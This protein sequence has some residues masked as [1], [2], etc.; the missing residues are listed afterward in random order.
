MI[1]TLKKI[2]QAKIVLVGA[3][4]SGAK[5]SSPQQL[6]IGKKG[7]KNQESFFIII[8][9]CWFQ[10]FNNNYYSPEHLKGHCEY[11]RQQTGSQ[12]WSKSQCK[13]SGLVC[14]GNQTENWAYKQLYIMIETKSQRQ[15]SVQRVWLKISSTAKAHHALHLVISC[16]TYTSSTGEGSRGSKQ[17]E[18]VE[19]GGKKYNLIRCYC[20]SSMDVTR[21]VRQRPMCTS[22][23]VVVAWAT[24]DQQLGSQAFYLGIFG[25]QDLLQLWDFCLWKKCGHF[26]SKCSGHLPGQRTTGSIDLQRL[27]N[28]GTV[29]MIIWWWQAS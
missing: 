3:W 4:S 17:A 19:G 28:N 6:L 16:W 24:S 27:L 26:W 29:F 5:P 22:L 1:R 10:V 21:L 25:G 18:C 9:V 11:L 15:L 13:H 12:L 14:S 23:C 8:K 7:E 20:I 2:H